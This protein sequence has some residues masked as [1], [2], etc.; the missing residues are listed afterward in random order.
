M[1]VEWLR[2]PS[3]NNGSA[4]VVGGLVQW[5]GVTGSAPVTSVKR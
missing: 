5:I 1:N 3:F 2:G 4:L